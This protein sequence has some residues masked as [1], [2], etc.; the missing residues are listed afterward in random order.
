M[1]ILKLFAVPSNVIFLLA[2]LGLALGI[3]PRTRRLGGFSLASAALLLV[4]FSCGK[5]ATWLLSPLEYEYP[6]VPDQAAPVRAIVVLAAYAANDPDMSLS[7]RP[8]SASLYRVV[9]GA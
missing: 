7:D 4:V 2:G 3:A 8:N 1:D 6:R 5:T 9:E